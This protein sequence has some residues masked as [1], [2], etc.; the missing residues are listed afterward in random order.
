MIDQTMVAEAVQY[1]A[2]QEVINNRAGQPAVWHDGLTNPD[3]GLPDMRPQELIHA[4]RTAITQLDQQQRGKVTAATLVRI[5]KEERMKTHANE[6]PGHA[7]DDPTAYPAWLKAWQKTAGQGMSKAERT[8]IADHAAENTPGTTWTRAK[9]EQP[10]ALTK[11]EQAILDRIKAGKPP[12]I[13]KPMPQQWQRH[14]PTT[15]PG[16][17][18]AA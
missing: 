12:A 5:V 15:P 2:A 3:T 16:P 8:A 4:C 11:A 13:G 14:R 17:Q 18:N 6:I 10:P 9:Q 7:P 1:L